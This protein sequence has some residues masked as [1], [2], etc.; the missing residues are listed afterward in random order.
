MKVLKIVFFP[1]TLIVWLIK[2]IVGQ[3]NKAYIAKFFKG[4]TISKIDALTGDEFEDICSLIFKY[5]GYNVEKTGGSGD[6]GADLVITKRFK[7]VVQA[8]L[9]Y[10]HGVGNK[11]VQEVSSALKYYK[12]DFACVI[13]NWKFTANAKTIAQIQNVVLIDR[14]D[15]IEFL[16]DVKN[17]TRKSKIF[18]LKQNFKVNVT[19]I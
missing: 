2:W 15:V 11:A 9:Y 19:N 10:N 1:I 17:G 18:N 16:T 6:Y 8:K 13:T 12:A 14:Q 5:A 4:I 3:C 7:V